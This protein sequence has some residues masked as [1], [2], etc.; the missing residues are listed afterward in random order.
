MTVYSEDNVFR[1]GDFVEK[2]VKI[3]EDHPEL[4]DLP[5]VQVDDENTSE[6]LD[7][8]SDM[9]G[10][11]VEVGDFIS[12]GDMIDHGIE[13]EIP[14]DCHMD[15]GVFTEMDGAP[16]EHRAKAVRLTFDHRYEY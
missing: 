8:V 4:A 3:I 14:D 12:Y 9:E 7:H 13:G 16:R 15:M 1:F 5:M 10:F 6:D 11:N 2:L